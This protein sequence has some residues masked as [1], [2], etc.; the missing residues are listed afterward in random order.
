MGQGIV[1]ET[2]NLSELRGYRTGRDDPRDRQQPDR[3][4]DPAR[5]GALHDLPHRRRQEHPGADLPRQ[6]RRPRGRLARGAHGDRVP[7]DVQAGRGDRICGATA[8]S[9]TTS[10]TSPATPSRACT[11]RS[12]QGKACGRP[13]PSSSRRRA[14]STPRASRSSRPTSSRRLKSAREA[15]KVEKQRGKVPSFSGAWNGITRAPSDYRDWQP[16][17]GVAAGTIREIVRPIESLPRDFTLN[18]KLQKLL[19]ERIAA[20][21]GEGG[22]RL[23]HRRDVSPTAACC[24]TASTCA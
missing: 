20:S 12:R 22:D 16:A 13:T 1:F 14:P 17:G 9:A 11:G 3:L 24:S 8:S 23:R 2:L 15:A 4:H 10:R 5:A 21:R 7:A 6:R 18:S 19:D